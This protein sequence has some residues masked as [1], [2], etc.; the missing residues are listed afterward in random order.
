MTA[1]LD[2]FIRYAELTCYPHG[3]DERRNPRVRFSVDADMLCDYIVK[4]GS[5]LE[6]HDAH[7]WKCIDAEI[8]SD[9]AYMNKRMFKSKLV[10]D[11]QIEYDRWHQKHE[12]VCIK[13]KLPKEKERLFGFKVRI[14]RW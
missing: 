13:Y 14:Y 2:G 8:A 3:F 4:N 1:N 7:F 10:M 11:P 6:E 9:E 12:V 5:T